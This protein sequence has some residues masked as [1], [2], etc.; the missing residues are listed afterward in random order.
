MLEETISLN[1]KS[2][3]ILSAVLMLALGIGFILGYLISSKA[4]QGG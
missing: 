4:R 2:G 3:L 1:L